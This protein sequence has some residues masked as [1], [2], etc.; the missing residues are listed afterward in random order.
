[1]KV[2]VTGASS[3]LGRT[4]ALALA[5]RGDSVTCF[6][7][8]ASGTELA[9][10]RGDIRD[11]AALLAAAAGHDALIHLAALVAP[12]AAWSDAYGVNVTGTVNAQR[13]GELCGRFVHISSPSV[14]FKNVPAVGVGAEPACYAGRDVYTRS[15]AIAEQL[16]LI[17]N[18]VPTIVVR[19]H[20]V[21]G[22]GDTQLVG[23][24]VARAKQHR[25]AVPGHG[26]ALIDTTYVD[27]AARAIIAAL[28]HAVPG[29][30]ACGK[31][32]VVTGAGRGIRWAPRPE[33]LARERAP[34]HSLRRSPALRSPLVRSARDPTGARL[35]TACFS[36][37]GPGALGR[38]V[39]STSLSLAHVA[40]GWATRCIRKLRC[41]LCTASTS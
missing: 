17:D 36:G 25:L 7:R 18:D 15:K 29:D 34:H 40:Q 2:V 26:R 14:A 22:P 21:W 33:L 19:P 35:D 10:V 13:A 30:E 20:L 28:D 38:V 5:E 9:E 41:P 11:G 23:R 12:R 6:Q 4:V 1:V 3:L 16:V 8:S 37:R 32:W 27:D 24:I 31:A 39:Q